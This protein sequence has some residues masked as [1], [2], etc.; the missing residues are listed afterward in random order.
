M[1]LESE[2]DIITR[3]IE[4]FLIFPMV[5]C[6][7]RYNKR[8]RSY[9]FLESIELLKFCS[10]QNRVSHEI[11]LFTPNQMQYQQT[12]NT[13]IVAKFLSFLMDICM[14]YSNNH[15]K[16]YSHRKWQTNTDFSKK[17]EIDSDW[18]KGKNWSRNR[19]KGT[20]RSHMQQ[21][22]WSFPIET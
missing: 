18:S 10:G 4:Y 21:G 13:S 12:F 2:H 7:P 9:N 15:N 16:S 3:V 11:W 20:N 1:W 14:N 22:S 19:I 8:F 6:M 17:P 5:N